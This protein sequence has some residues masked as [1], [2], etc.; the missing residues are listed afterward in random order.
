MWYIAVGV[1]LVT[2]CALINQ[3]DHLVSLF[4]TIVALC[5]AS[6]AVDSTAWLCGVTAKIAVD[7]NMSSD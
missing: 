7:S 6:V 5:G 3:R 4:N 2:C 1:H